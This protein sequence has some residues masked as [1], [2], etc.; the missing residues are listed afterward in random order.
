MKLLSTVTLSVFLFLTLESISAQE[1]NTGF[2]KIYGLD[3][4][5][6]NGEIYK[7]FLRSDTKG[8]Q[9]LAGPGFTEGSV[10]I[11][12]VTYDHLQLNY[13]VFNQLVLLKYDNPLSTN[14]IISLSK[15]W[16]VGF[17]MGTA[18][19]EMIRFQDTS[20]R[21]C[22]VLGKGKFR[23]LYYWTKEQ[24]IDFYY[25]TPFYVFLPPKKEMFLEIGSEHRKF[26]NNR[27]FLSAFDPS[28]QVSIKKYMRLNKI[29]TKKADDK[30]M[31]ELITF[32]NTLY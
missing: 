20:L 13:D 27:N 3:P 19:F 4:K 5:L 7:Y 18:N 9:Y 10:I 28:I 6:Y 21:I 25:Y 17:S 22:Q 26:R 16:L 29:D 1:V 23:L 32:C 24:K 14:N 11:K 2:D 15:A 31:L 12:G 30:T 8:N